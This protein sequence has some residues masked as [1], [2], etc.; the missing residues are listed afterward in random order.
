MSNE[1]LTIFKKTIR[2]C[3]QLDPGFGS[4]THKHPRV[5][6]GIVR[7]GLAAATIWKKFA[8]SEPCG[9]EFKMTGP[10][11]CRVT[12]IHTEGGVSHAEGTFEM[13]FE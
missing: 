10:D 7:E 11:S 3:S 4:Y 12:K 1:D 5:C 9:Y 6:A 13:S 8:Q 2:A